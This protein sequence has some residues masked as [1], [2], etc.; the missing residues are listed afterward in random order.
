MSVTGG[1]VIS[2]RD[3]HKY[4]LS[5]QKH[6]HCSSSVAAETN[7]I[8]RYVRLGWKELYRPSINAHNLMLVNASRR[9]FL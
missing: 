5:H 7:N 8:A 9:I 2:N 3:A 1:I 4:W 6:S